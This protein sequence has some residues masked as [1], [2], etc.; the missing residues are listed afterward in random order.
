MSEIVEQTEHAIIEARRG[1]PE[2]VVTVQDT[3]EPPNLVNCVALIEILARRI[4]GRYLSQ[5]DKE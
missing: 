5:L 2:T 4:A 1:Q 3:N